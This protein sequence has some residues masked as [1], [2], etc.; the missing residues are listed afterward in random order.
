LLDMPDREALTMRRCRIAL[1]LLLILSVVFCTSCGGGGDGGDVE[2]STANLAAAPS[3]MS[4][5]ESCDG[6]APLPSSLESVWNE[7]EQCTVLSSEPPLVV[8]SPTVVCPRN[9]LPQCLATVPFFPCSN[10]P[11]QTCGAIGRF[12]PSCN[13]IELPDRYDGAAAHEMIH[14]LLRSQGRSDWAEHDSA[15]FACQ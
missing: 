7:T 12:L 15:E 6:A 3:E 2:S 8:L 14:H 5:P 4:S 9:Q 11:S 1:D 13:A 10:D